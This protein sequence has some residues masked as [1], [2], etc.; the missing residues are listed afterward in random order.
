M[1]IIISLLTTFFILTNVSFSFSFEEIEKLKKMGFSNEDIVNLKGKD[2]SSK[3]PLSS[4]DV[5]YSMKFGFFLKPNSMTVSTVVT[6]SSADQGGLKAGDELMK[7]NRKEASIETLEV[8]ERSSRVPFIVNR[9]GKVK[10]LRLNRDYKVQDAGP[11]IASFLPAVGD[12]NDEDRID[13]AVRIIAHLNENFLQRQNKPP[14]KFF[15][16][17]D[18]IEFLP[19]RDPMEKYTMEE[20]IKLGNKLRVRYIFYWEGINFRYGSGTTKY[21]MAINVVDV[22][23]QS[24]LHHH[25]IAAS[26]S[27]GWSSLSKTECYSWLSGKYYFRLEALALQLSEENHSMY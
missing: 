8:L 17:R 1:K 3:S 14:I 2:S 4:Q 13:L 27:D 21:N 7:V 26:M 5:S 15:P 24:I 20:V 18:L 25:H 22:K 9:S 12:I 11:Y 10:L 6:G 23:K 16:Y 19:K